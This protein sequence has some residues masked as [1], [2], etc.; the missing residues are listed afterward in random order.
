MSE[1]L[2]SCTEEIVSL[3]VPLHN[4]FDEIENRNAFSELETLSANLSPFLQI[5][6]DTSLIQKEQDLTGASQSMGTSSPSLRPVKSCKPLRPQVKV[7]TDKITLQTLINN[8]LANTGCRKSVLIHSRHFNSTA[9]HQLIS[10]PYGFIEQPSLSAPKTYSCNGLGELAMGLSHGDHSSMKLVEE[11]VRLQYQNAC[12]QHADCTRPFMFD[13]SKIFTCCLPGLP[14][15]LTCVCPGYITPISLSSIA[16]IK[17]LKNQPVRVV[18]VQG[19]LTENYHHPGFNESTNIKTVFEN[20]KANQ[21]STEE[22]WADHLLQMLIQFNVHLVLAQG[23]VSKRLIEKCMYSKRLVIGSVNGSVM[24]AFAEATGAV[25]VTYVTQVNEDCV[26]NGVSVTFWRSVPL[27]VV[28][29]KDRVAI[30]LKTEGIN[31]ITAVLAE[32][33]IAQMEA[34]EDKFW[35]CAYRLHYAIKEKKVFLG[36][37]AVELL[38]LS[39]LQMIEAQSLKEDMQGCSGWLHNSSPSLASSLALYRPTVLKCLANGWHKYLSTLLCNTASYSS[40]VEASTFIQRHL[41][42]AIDS[43]VP[44]TYILNEYSKLHSGIFNPS[45][46]VIWSQIPRV[47]D[48]ITP[49]IEAWRR[50]LDLVLLVLQTDC[51]IVT[52]HEHTKLNSQESEGILF[53]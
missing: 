37:G 26:G 52:G 15:T 28:D 18:L 12:V 7:D 45:I 16:L 19:D 20:M 44:S 41:E 17:E 53:L 21:D 14:D 13:I 3:Q 47:F 27:N 33:V 36:G 4:L 9:N 10:K 5:P 11:A 6:S 40:E 31:F 32:P 8:Q 34:K 48:T 1:G 23:N 29:K 24:Q 2:N 25:Q 51:E 42:N 49:K 43:G 30:L 50:A 39:H 46:S 35:T 22:L 38:C